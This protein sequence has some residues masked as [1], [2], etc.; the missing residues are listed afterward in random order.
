MIITLSQLP[1]GEGFGINTNLLET[2][3]LNLA[4]VVG[5]LVY[6]GGDILQSLLTNR[7][8]LIVKSLTDA[9]E[10]FKEATAK[11]EAAKE[12]LSLA[13]TKAEEI[14]VQGLATASQGRTN[15]LG[16]AEEDMKR[17]EDTKEVSLRFEEEKAVQEVSER[18]R[19]LALQQAVQT[20]NKR[21][22]SSLQRRVIDLNIALFEWIDGKQIKT[23]NN[24]EVF[25]AINFI[26]KLKK[27]PRSCLN[28]YLYNAVEPCFNLNDIKNQINQKKYNLTINNSSKKIS[29][30][31]NKFFNPTLKKVI[32]NNISKKISLVKI[33]KQSLILS[34]S[35]FGFHNCLKLKNNK[36]IFLDFEYFGRDDAI[37]LVSDFLL[38]PGMRLTDLQKKF[39]TKKM[40]SIFKNDVFFKR[41]LSAFIPYYAL[42][43]SLIALND[44]KIKNVIKYCKDNRIDKFKFL[45]AR[46]SQLKKAI[47]FCNIAKKETY[48]KWLNT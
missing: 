11:L 5:V 36:F 32:K 43:W 28:K 18:V 24:L 38:H 16:R 47:L 19:E 9:E 14:R 40:L 7:K 2:N 29:S 39:W 22:D 27:I 46:D 37:K 48:K 41:R 42:R 12:Q 34:P 45:N 35:D 4:V 21:L 26:K 30:F 6:F 23:V 33:N 1:L 13:K 44:F 25:S 17:L 3:V 8:E 15:L 20:V 10:R 31:I